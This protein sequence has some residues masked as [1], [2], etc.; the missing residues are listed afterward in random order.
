M[1]SLNKVLLI[2]GVCADPE[3]TNTRGGDIVAKLR[4]AM[5]EKWKKNGEQ[6]EKTEY[7][8]V[9]AWGDGI[10]GVIEQYVMK[11]SKIHVEGKLTTRSWEKDGQKHY[12]TEVLLSNLILLTSPRKSDDGGGGRSSSRRDDPPPRGRDD[13]GGRRP[14]STDLDDE[15]P[16]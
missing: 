14:A 3:I 1:S 13:R 12:T 11:G 8:N 6:H 15:I 10:C 9:V 7:I 2:G 5:T 16:F 4:L